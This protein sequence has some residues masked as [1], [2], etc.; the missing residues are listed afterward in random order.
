M[1]DAAAAALAVVQHQLNLQNQTAE[2]PFATCL[3]WTLAIV[4]AHPGLCVQGFQYVQSQTKS[5]WDRLQTT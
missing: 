2:L 5:L 4:E 1:P 3:C